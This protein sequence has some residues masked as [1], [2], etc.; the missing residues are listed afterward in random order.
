MA[1]RRKFFMD[2]N[3]VGAPKPQNSVLENFRLYSR[4]LVYPYIY[5]VEAL[6]IH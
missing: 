1:A 2:K 6:N 5:T 4:L 3:F